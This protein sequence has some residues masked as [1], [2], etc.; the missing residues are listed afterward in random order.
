MAATGRFVTPLLTAMVTAL[1][2]MPSFAASP[3]GAR[4]E[5]LANR[6]VRAAARAA[7]PAQPL[8]A[9]R[10]LQS[11]LGPLADVRSAPVSGAVSYVGRPTGLLTG[12]SSDD[13]RGIA[14]GYVRDHGEVFGLTK[15]DLANLEL[16]SSDVSPDGIRH[17]RFNQILDGIE[18]F[19]SG[20]EAHVTADGRLI[21]VTGAPLPDAKLSATKPS[22]DALAG[23]GAAR[24]AAGGSGPPPRETA[25]KPGPSRLTAFVTGE[26]ARLRWSA[27]ADGPVLAWNVITEG[28]DGH[29]YDVL[30]DARDGALLRRQD[31]TQHLGQ[32][33]VFQ[34]S[35]DS[36]PAP[37]QLS[38]PPAWYDDH[39]G[40]TRLWGQF[41][42]TYADPADADPAGGSE[43]DGALVQIPASDA[44]AAD[45]LFTQ[46][47]TFPGATPCP[48]SGCT[49]NSASPLTE[50]TNRSQAGSNLH[51]LVSGFHDYLAQAPIGFDEASGNFQRTNTSPQG[52]GDDYVRSEVN[53]GGGLDNA[54]MS[55]PPDGSPPRM[56]MYLF[57]ARDVNG[58]DDADIVYH[59]Y[60]HGLSNRLVVNAAGG[61]TLSSIQSLMMGEAWSDFY[62][63]DRL[64]AEGAATDSPAPAEMTTGAYS[65]GPGGVR[66]KPTDCPVN[67]SGDAGCND[68]GTATTVLGGYTYGDLAVTSN[69][70]PH[71][72]GEVWAQTVWDIRTALGH[73]PALALIT[74]GMRLSPDNPSM[75]DMRDA[76]LQQAIAMRS[77]PGAADDHYPALWGIF[78]SR[79]M[80]ADASTPSANSTNPSEAFNMPSGLRAR[81]TTLR[82]P[83]PGGD[84]DGQIEPGERF[85]VDQ[86]IE[87]IGLA[88]LPG[89]T[90][91]LS[92][93]DPALTIEDATADWPSLGQGR[94]AVNSDPLAARLPAGSC[95]ASS[96]IS[97]DVTSTEGNVVASSV[98]DPRPGSSTV[99]PLLD[100][101]SGGPGVVTTP[102]IATGGGDV[103]DV[104]VRIDDLRHTWLGDLTIE[105]EHD[106]VTAVLFSRLGDGLFSGDDVVNTI[107]DSDAS[108][109]LP[110]SGPGPISGRFDTQPGTALDLDAFDGHPAAGTWTL[111]ITDLAEQD[112]G[113]L[114]RWGLDSPQVGCG[115]AE[116]P[117]A[118][119]GV[120]T[121]VSSSAATLAGS[122]T[123]NG[124]ATDLRFSYGT[125]TG[126]GT[127]T[128]VQ[129][130][131]AGDGAAARTSDLT[132]LAPGTT[133]HFRVEAIR[134]GGAVAVTGEDRTFTTAGGTTPPP[135]PPPVT[136]PPPPPPVSPPPPPPPPQPPPPPG[137]PIASFISSSK[138][139]RVSKAGKFTYAFVASPS[140]SGNVTLVST[141]R[142]KIGSAKR[143]MKLGTKSFT[144]PA[145]AIV[146]VKFKLSSKNLKALKKLKSVKLAIVVTL[147][148]REFRGSLKLKR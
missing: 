125:T 144:S 10:A 134:E 32:N 106:G 70:S 63:L 27:T 2:A 12:P 105:L 77:A 93:G 18:S 71:N 129:D 59:E 36:T 141:K 76:I 48:A 40:G 137:D 56:Q 34:R 104:D 31:L 96:P 30:V 21:N 57:S 65:F 41:S 26:R 90:G 79:G 42:R 138:S 88:D 14:L 1:A 3:P 94:R 37:T 16:V 117:V 145:S 24:R 85:V 123:P 7:V 22:L 84:N 135:P 89:V 142:V 55:T 121:G 73:T 107:L 110:A 80:G 122:V 69:G 81:S 132:G 20:L 72:G 47:H 143:T 54:N 53:D 120:A 95:S 146:W 98:V 99:V 115:R 6:D 140:S 13:P 19:D 112:S 83:Y 102:F 100:A 51:V 74:G 5:G 44:A 101:G 131:G 62:A 87:G 127:S 126:Y 75:L 52:L 82:D 116:I 130:V 119:T 43:G 39:A 92:S 128:P 23:L 139:L 9:R 50:A 118:V 147:G 64:V 86:S 136:P 111:R 11:A 33:K 4:H 113:E 148:G 133:Y 35:P 49:W 67:P 38:M 109:A 28:S 61:S 108:G 29:G 97:I 78:A 15:S 25:V 66:A 60:T 124:R 45:W 46:S 114:R 68:N 17:L 91:T 8:A 103:T 58:S